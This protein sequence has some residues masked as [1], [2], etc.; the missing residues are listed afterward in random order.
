MGIIEIILFAVL[1]VVCLAGLA[2][3]AL[4]A[5]GTW[6][7]FIAALAYD[8]LPWTADISTTAILL[9][10]GMAVLGEALEYIIGAKS[11]KK[12]GASNWGVAGAI[13]G[14]IIGAFVGVPVFLVGSVLGLFIG[15][16]LGAF[17]METLAKKSIAKAFRA[18]IGAFRG[19]V[20]AMLVKGLLGIAMV[21]TIITAAL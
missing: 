11:T 15:A 1:M 20:G 7:I 9:L 18:G 5:P 2:A 12:Y 19:R 13:A 21:I 17:V 16:F 8:L 4:G 10:L 3:T 14:G 6:V